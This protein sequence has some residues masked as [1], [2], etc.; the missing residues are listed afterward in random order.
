MKK[1]FSVIDE[2]ESFL[3]Q[4]PLLRDDDERLMVNIWTKH[5]GGFDN[6]DNF[7]AKEVLR[8]IAYHKLPSFESISRCRRKLQEQ[9]P[10][11]RGE[12]WYE[13]H[14]RAAKIRKEIVHD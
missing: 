7:S 13:R 6:L 11:L 12:K 3:I 4:F 9:C 10:N 1:L 2:V 14:K 8:M 5:I